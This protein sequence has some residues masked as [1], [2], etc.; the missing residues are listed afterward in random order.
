MNKKWIVRDN[1]PQSF[2]EQHPELPPIVAN[3]LYH[4]G[5]TEPA[6][7][8]EFLNPDYTQDIFDPY[9][10]LDMQKA[11]ER[12][13]RA[14]EQNEKITIHGDYDADGVCAATILMEMLFALGHTNASVFLPTAK[15]MDMDSTKRMFRCSQILA[16]NL[17]SPV[18]V[19]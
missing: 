3:L 11:I 10:F 9:L 4:R 7:I 13:N 19:V 5:V 2:L 17:S 18:T 15:L 14:I 1:P 16:Q 6:K 8:D 12:I